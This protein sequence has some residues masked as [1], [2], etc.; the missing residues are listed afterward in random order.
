MSVSQPTEGFPVRAKTGPSM[1]LPLHSTGDHNGNAFPI[2]SSSSSSSS[3]CLGESSPESLRS[4]SSLS[5][6]RTDSPL[7]YDMFEVTL[8]TTVTT[9][10]EQPTDVVV[11]KWVPEEEGKPDGDDDVSVGKIQTVTEVSESNDNSVSVYVDANSCEYR[12]DTWDDNDNLTLALSLTINSGSRSNNDDPSSGSSNG[13][14]HGSSTPDSDATEIPADDDDDNE[15][16]ALFLSVSSDVDVRRSSMTL[17]SSISQSSDSTVNPGGSAATTEIHSE[18]TLA[19]DETVLEEV[20]VVS[21]PVE[22]QTEPP[23]SDDRHET[24]QVS[25]SAHPDE[26]AKE[27]ASPPPEESGSCAAS[28]KP[29]KPNTSQPAR[30]AKSKPSPAAATT[31]RMTASTAVKPSSLE[32]K[33]VSKVDLKDVETKVRSRSYS[34]PPKTPNQNKFAAANG[35]RAAPRK[36]EAQTGDVGRKQRSSTGPVKVAVLLKSI[37]GKN[38]DPKTNHK[39]AANDSTQPERKSLAISRNLSTSTSSLGSEV[40]EEGPLGSPRKAVQEV[41]DKHETGREGVE[42]KHPSEDAHGGTGK[43]AAEKPRNLSRKVS[44]KLGP[45]ARQPGRGAKLEKG[46]SGPAPPPGSGTVPPGQGSLGPKQSDGSTLG[47]SGQ[48]AGGG[49]PT[50]TRPSQSQCQGIPKPRTTSERASVSAVPSPATSNSKPTAN[51]QPASGPIRRPAAPAA[52]K[53]PVKGLPTSLSSSSLGSTEISGAVSKASPTSPVAP[54]PSGTKP[55]EPPSRSVPPVGSPST[56]KPLISNTAAPA[57][58]STP[59]E[60]VSSGVAVAPK[61]PAMRSRALSLQAR[62]TATGLKAPTVTN[63]N[64]AKT[65]AANQ[66]AAKTS[67]A[68]NQALTKPGSQYPLQRSGSARLS[69]LNSTVDKNKPRETPA[70][71]VNN[72]SSSQLAPAGGNNQKKQQPPPDL[73]PDVVNANAPVAAAL[74]VPVPDTTNTGSGTTGASGPGPKAKTGSRSSPK[75]ASRLQNAPKPGAA[76]AA[77]AERM[78]AAK[79]NQSKEQAEKKNQAIIQLRKLLIQGNKRV[80]ALATVIQHLFS[81]REEALKQKRGLTQELANLREE[82]VAS[83]QSCERLQKGK[84]EVR[85]SLEEALNKLEEQHKEELVQLEERLR[86][87]YQ[88]EWDKVHQTYQEEAD[89]YRLLMEQQVEELRNQQEA[90]RK[91]QEVSHSQKIESLIVQYEAATEELKRIQQ[92][93]LENLKKTL[94]ETETSLSEKISELSAEKEALNEKLKAEEERRKQILTDKNLKDS[95]TVYLE[96]ELES[97]KVVLEIKNN[98]LHQK[99]KKLMEMDKLLETNVKLEECLKKVQQE[100]EDYKARMDKHAAISKQLSS[101]QAKLQQTLQ[102]ESKVNKRLSM[103]NEELL[104]KLH[105]GD[106]LASPRRLSPTS[107][108][109]SPR[110]SASFPTA[111]PLSPR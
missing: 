53:L 14:R 4:L 21:P 77:V 46:L 48:S 57:S 54:A 38:S 69:R 102:K 24:I 30:A 89:R 49:S 32:A 28:P 34:S 13:R 71:P 6:G 82:L 43:A 58:T 31:V 70:R 94:T 36:E 65:A 104:W 1:R 108:F 23:A 88:T 75:T 95:H 18:G 33:R 111:A 3:S 41:P 27:I 74:P 47:E 5:G 91:N 11:S 7:D 107:P 92:L 73:I 106:L 105:N 42:S 59:S 101:E 45:N 60:A 103:E 79:Q 98:Q 16:E 10:T 52:S 9:K 84:E 97:L 19:D 61:P 40:V 51:Q 25:S 83:S 37:R 78:V 8:M 12:Q 96:Q 39:T 35:K 90:E 93:D 76:G 15:E 55:D 44:S 2:S 29:P 87:F 85:V 86:S 109:N 99:E 50:R 68:A 26:D 17:T 67:P 66:T 56:A 62:T 72:N 81:E 100:N 20:G 80:E 63:H 22:S 110:N 64:I